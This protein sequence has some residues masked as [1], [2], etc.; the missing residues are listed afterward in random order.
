MKETYS[1]GKHRK[2]TALA[3]KINGARE[4]TVW[5]CDTREL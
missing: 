2:E 1:E 3:K 4:D 5:Y